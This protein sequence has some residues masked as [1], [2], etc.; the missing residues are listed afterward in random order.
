MPTEGGGGQELAKCCLRSLCMP[1]MQMHGKIFDI[2]LIYITQ[3]IV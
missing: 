2:L 1:P 3:R